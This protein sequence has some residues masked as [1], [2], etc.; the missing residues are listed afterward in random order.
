MLTQQP[1]IARLRDRLLRQRRRLVVLG[2]ALLAA[3]QQPLQL[4]LAKADQPEVEAELGEVRQ[5][6]P[7][8]LLVPA[9]VQRQLVVGKHIRPLLRLAHVRKLDHRHLLQ[10]E[11]SRGHDPAVPGD[12]AALTIDQYRVRPAELPDAR[13]DLRHLGIA[14]GA[15][16]AGIRDQLAQRAPGDREIVHS[17]NLTK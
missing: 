9:R 3:R 5:L 4:A 12:D 16:I 1:Q 2:Q 7:Q 11:L 10:P 15:R 6:E 8:Q 17:Q 13:C 14:M